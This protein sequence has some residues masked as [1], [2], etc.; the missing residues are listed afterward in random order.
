MDRDNRKI[1][2]DDGMELQIWTGGVK[3]GE[4][5]TK[6][7]AENLLNWSSVRRTTGILTAGSVSEGFCCQ[8]VQ[9]VETQLPAESAIA[10]G[11]V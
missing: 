11:P 5:V 1:G 7:L 4:P 8:A 10:C 2:I 9:T 3:V 6:M